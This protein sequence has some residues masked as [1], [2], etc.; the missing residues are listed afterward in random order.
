LDI[1]PA[2]LTGEE[3]CPP[4]FESTEIIE[5]EKVLARIKA[6]IEILSR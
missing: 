1:L 3:H 2:T 5:R 4:L 6:A